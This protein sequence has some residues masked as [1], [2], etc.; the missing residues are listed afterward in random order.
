M[1][2]YFLVNFFAQLLFLRNYDIL[3]VRYEDI[4][5]DPKGQLI[6]IQEHLFDG[7]VTKINPPTEIQVPHIIGGNRM[8]KQKKISITPDFEWKKNMARY[9]QLFYYFAMWPLMAIN[10]YKP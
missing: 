9:K 2:Y 3:K 1:V 10:R 8:K 4:V 5:R 7:A 6:K